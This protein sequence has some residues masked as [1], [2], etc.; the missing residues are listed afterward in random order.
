MTNMSETFTNI[1]PVIDSFTKYIFGEDSDTPLEKFMI[2]RFK[3]ECVKIFAGNIDLAYIE[4]IAQKIKDNPWD[5][6]SDEIK[7]K[8]IAKQSEGLM[9]GEVPEND[10]SDGGGS[11]DFGG[12]SDDSGGSDEEDFDF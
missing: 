2:Q 1:E 6:I 12:S 9:N 8:I 3:K 5:G 10:S 11:D 4:Q 7:N